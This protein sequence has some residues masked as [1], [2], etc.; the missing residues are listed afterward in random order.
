MITPKTDQRD[1]EIDHEVMKYVNVS[2]WMNS[3][4]FNVIST[5]TKASRIAKV[6]KIKTLLHDLIDK[7]TILLECIKLTYASR[8]QTDRRS[9]V[10]KFCYEK[11][12]VED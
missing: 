12:E 11:T 3:T 8:D 5:R 4:N 6:L 2:V 9:P 1:T 10:A 7:L